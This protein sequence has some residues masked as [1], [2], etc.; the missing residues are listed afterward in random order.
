MVVKSD[1]PTD[2]LNTKREWSLEKLVKFLVWLV[3][4]LIV[5]ST[6]SFIRSFSVQDSADDATKA[7]NRVETS[8]IEGRDAA[9]ETL[10]GFRRVITEYEESRAN[11][12]QIDTQF[13]VETFQAIARMEAFLCQGPCPPPE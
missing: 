7:A 1:E 5:I 11:Q 6:A 2:P 10:Q 3:C 4:V 8:S 12:P 13:V 9:L